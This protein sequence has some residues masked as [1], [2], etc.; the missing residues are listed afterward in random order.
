MGFKRR[1]GVLEYWSDGVM[2][3]NKKKTPRTPLL[4]YSNTPIP[5]KKPGAFGPGFRR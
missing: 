5:Q 4:R 1:V 2:V 3:R